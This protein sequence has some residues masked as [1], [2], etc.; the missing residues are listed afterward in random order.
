MLYEYNYLLFA[1]FISYH[2][3]VVTHHLLSDVSRSVVSA[4]RRNAR[5]YKSDYVEYDSRANASTVNKYCSLWRRAMFGNNFRQCCAFVR[6]L[7]GSFR[8]H[9]ASYKHEYKLHG[10]SP[11]NDVMKPS[12]VLDETRTAHACRY[13]CVLRRRAL[14]QRVT[15]CVT[16]SHCIPSCLAL[17]F[18]RPFSYDGFNFISTG[19]YVR[20]EIVAIHNRELR[21]RIGALC[22]SS[23]QAT[24]IIINTVAAPGYCARRST[25]CVFRQS[26]EIT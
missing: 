15:S 21:C 10:R 20:R 4:C 6:R 2:D 14:V 11:A 8:D 3:K 22:C 7:C 23:R 13:I 25:A 17:R 5:V 18:A 16:W 26:V 1:G 19:V 24:Y 9:Q 12:R